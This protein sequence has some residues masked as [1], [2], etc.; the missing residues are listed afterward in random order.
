M[1]SSLT[2]TSAPRLT[3]EIVRDIIA[4]DERDVVI[5]S[6]EEEPGS[7]RGDN[8]TSMLYRIRAKGIKSSAFDGNRAWECAIIYK[9]LPLSQEHR[10]TYKSEILF[11]NEVAFYTHVWPTLDQLQRNV[12]KVFAGVAKIYL[13]RSDLIA[14]EDLKEKGYVMADR[15]KGL[16]V[17]HLK[18]VLEALAGFHA[19]SLTLKS[20]RY[21]LFNSIPKLLSRC[22]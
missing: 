22:D 2:E 1:D 15:Q 14:M 20:T 18:L 17:H 4:K 5:E 7:G 10:D 13:A 9:V 3:L 6:I 19:L 11:R 21:Y 16:Q 12:K 8:Y